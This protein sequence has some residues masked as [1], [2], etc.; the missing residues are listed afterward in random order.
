MILL[1]NDVYSFAK[2]PSCITVTYGVQQYI[3]QF[4]G[5]L[6]IVKGNFALNIYLMYQ[7]HM[8]TVP[9]MSYHSIVLSSLFLYEHLPR[10]GNLLAILEAFQSYLNQAFY[11]VPFS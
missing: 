5:D 6:R 10:A 4:M 9:L 1:V 3:V 8:E 2:V 11:L 7:L